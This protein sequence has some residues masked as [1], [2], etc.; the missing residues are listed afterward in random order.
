MSLTF[1]AIY[2]DGVLKP[3]EPLPLKEHEKVTVT[4]SSGQTWVERTSGIIPC[5]DARI[6]EWAAEDAELEYPPP[7]EVL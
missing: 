2:E 1:E 3:I 5:T 4:L 7:S 6:I